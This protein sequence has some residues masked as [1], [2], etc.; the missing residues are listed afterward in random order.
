[1]PIDETL[2]VVCIATKDPP[3]SSSTKTPKQHSRGHRPLRPRHGHRNRRLTRDQASRRAHHPN[4]PGPRTPP[5]RPRSGPPAPTR[6]PH[7][8]P[9]RLRRRPT[10]KP[11]RVDGTNRKIEEEEAIRAIKLLCRA[12][13]QLDEITRRGCNYP[14]RMY[15]FCFCVTFC[16]NFSIAIN[17]LRSSSGSVKVVIIP[18][19]GFLYLPRLRTARRKGDNGDDGVVLIS[20][21]LLYAQLASSLV[22]D[23]DGR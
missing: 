17:P 15:S 6:L 4:P 16:C 2:P 3:A 13:R 5:P 19:L 23:A 11:G 18:V 7:S 9:P 22:L 21:I 1:M 14:R 20:V 10:K 12:Q 8:R